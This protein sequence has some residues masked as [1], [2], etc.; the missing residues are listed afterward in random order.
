MQMQMFT[1]QQR[2]IAFI[3][4][5]VSRME[6]MA[7][8]SHSTA[9]ASPTNV[10]EFPMNS[11]STHLPE[12]VYDLDTSSTFEI[13]Y[14]RDEDVISK[15]GAAMDKAAKARRHHIRSLHKPHTSEKSL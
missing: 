9:P 8:G 15:D 12:F 14:N 1:E 3:A 13:W 2:M 5:L 10:A 7:Y 11:L 6:G 4:K